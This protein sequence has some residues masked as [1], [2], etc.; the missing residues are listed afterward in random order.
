MRAELARMNGGSKQF[1]LR[2][3]RKEIDRFYFEHGPDATMAEF[4]MRQGT[5]ER[6]LNPARRGEDL[7]LD[8]LSEGD[9][10]VLRMAN[11]GIS[12][13]RSRLVELESWRAA[14]A[15]VITLVQALVDAAS[16][17]IKLKVDTSALPPDPLRMDNFGRSPKKEARAVLT[18]VM[19]T[20]DTEATKLS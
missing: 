10:T 3:H 13:L 7:R 11:A 4:N 19:E 15:P 20:S 8:R 18:T 14:A 12:E 2:V 9:R 5:L 17:K 6:F 1:W 16:D